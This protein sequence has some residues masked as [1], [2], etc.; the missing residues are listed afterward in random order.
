MA[1]AER[2]LRRFLVDRIARC[3]ELPAAD[4]DPDRLLEQYGIA[5]R[6]AI[7][8][9]A[10]LE[11]V[12]GRQLEPSSLWRYP[13]L[14]Q[15]IRGI[16]STTH[17]DG[18]PLTPLDPLT[19]DEIAV[20][21]LG[22]RGSDQLEADH[23]ALEHAG[24][25]PHTQAAVFRT[26]TVLQAMTSLRNGESDLAVAVLADDGCQVAVLKR[27]ADTGL[28]Q[29][30]ALCIER[31]PA[32]PVATGFFEAVL[33]ADRGFTSDLV[34]WPVGRTASTPE[35]VVRRA[36]PAEPT[37]SSGPTRLL[38][39]DV[40]IDGIQQYAGELA[41]YLRTNSAAGNADV[42]H[43]L[44]RRLGRGP[45]RAAVVGRT[46]ADLT[47]A[48][49]SLAKGN[50]HPGV[51]SGLATSEPPQPVW[52][53]PG[54]PADIASSQSAA[55]L[56]ELAESVPG[57]AGL[58]VELD[59]LVV[60]AT[61]VSVRE[62]VRT[63]TLPT[64][65][66]LPVAFAVQVALAL[67][68]RQYGVVPAAIVGDGAGEAAAAVVAGA[69]TATEG[70]QVIAAMAS[71]PD[72]LTSALADLAPAAPRLPFY[73]AS[74]T[75]ATPFGAEYWAASLKQPSDPSTTLSRAALDGHEL[76]FHLTADALAFHT[77]LA[78]LEVLGQP[79]IPPPGRI[80]DVP[81]APWRTA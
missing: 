39:S 34:P 31:D 79:V 53:F 19:G 51:L 20:I 23:E 13:T 65:G 29:V 24:I 44:A 11:D 75:K 50:N 37:P 6:D 48:L 55:G 8:I 41:T 70:A 16:L 71:T 38:L 26:T 25:P 58:I 15:L 36:Q 4:V 81:V 46:R 78:T 42:A 67:S 12:L 3:C 27:L 1:I 21:G 18:I 54:R 66:E 32:E 57:F 7:A 60:W 17:P 80:T 69:L 33:A 56:R 62:A 40:S 35:A 28:D 47:A 59:P 61:G 72:Q 74:S 45:V 30:L 52:V 73:S 22:C 14:N 49:T 77:Q 5:S 43:T 64:G 63:S 9:T 68:L 10:E 2:D 76:F